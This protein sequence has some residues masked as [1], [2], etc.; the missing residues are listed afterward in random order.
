MPIRSSSAVLLALIFS[1]VPAMGQTGDTARLKQNLQICANCHGSAAFEN[2]TIDNYLAPRLGGQQVV[3]IIKALKAYK[4]RQRHHFFM[5]GIA[6][7]LNDEEM[8]E[9]A[10]YFS[11][12]TLHE[13]VENE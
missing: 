4:T 5:R 6:A 12:Q 3:Y 13:E 9:L 8:Q 7:S 11:R 1:Y 10:D 2:P